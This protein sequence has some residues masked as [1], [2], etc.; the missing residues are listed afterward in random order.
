MALRQRHFSTTW[1]T[2]A[3]GELELGVLDGRS[4]VDINHLLV[5]ASS[6]DIKQLCGVL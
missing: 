1:G 5:L 4:S 2:R 3:S 6:I